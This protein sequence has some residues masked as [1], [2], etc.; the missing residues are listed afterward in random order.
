M[1]GRKRKA[2]EE[3]DNDRMSTSPTNSPSVSS[4]SLPASSVPRGI[5]RTRT[6][7]SGGRP[8]PLARLL[9]TLSTDEMRQLLQDI[10]DQRPDIKHEIITRAPRPSVEST[11]AVLAKYETDFRSAFPFG[12]R[13]TS[14]YAYNRV[15]Q[16]LHQLLEALRDFTPYYLPPQETQTATSLNYLDAATNI[17]HRLPDW[18]TFAHQRHKQEAYDE[19]TRAWALVFKGAGKTA[20]GLRL[21]FGGWDQ[22]LAEHNQKSGGKLEE[23]V[24]EL[25]KALGFMHSE[26]APATPAGMDDRMNIRQQLLSGTYGQG[27]GLGVG[28]GQW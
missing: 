21:Q 20:G 3:P 15:R 19:I 17:I 4:R 28:P 13:S 25:R 11:L 18:D 27:Q 6:N 2:S 7:A 8:L 12:N 14:D 26:S 10:C 9:Q 23:A 24:G 1:S 5:K 22:K 16:H